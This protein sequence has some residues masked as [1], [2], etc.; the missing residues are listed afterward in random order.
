MLAHRNKKHKLNLD[1]N[2]RKKQYYDTFIKTKT[3]EMLSEKSVQF[4]IYTSESTDISNFDFE[5]A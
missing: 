3:S 5:E 2:R 1:L 4:T